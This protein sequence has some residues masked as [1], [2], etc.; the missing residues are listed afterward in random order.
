MD[1][2]ETAI[3][4]DSSLITDHCS[5]GTQ[6]SRAL[7][8]G[9]GLIKLLTSDKKLILLS[10]HSSCP[11]CNRSFEE[12]DPRLFS[13]NSPHG[14]CTE[15]R[16]HGR[17]PKRRHHLDTSRF[18]SVLA[19]ELDADRSIERMDDTE[20]IACPAC[21]GSRLNP[22]A[23]AVRL[24]GVW[25]SRPQ[26]SL[27]ISDLSALSID[28]SQNHFNKLT[29]EESRQNLIARDI[30]PEIRQR[31]SFLQEVG[32]GYLQLDRSGNTLSGGESQRIR[33]A[34][35]LGSNLR[36]VLYVL[37]EPTIGLH[38]RDNAALLKT[39][40]KLRD[41]GNSLIIVE[42]DED[43]IAAADHLIDLGPAAGRLGGEIVY[44]GKPP[45]RSSQF[46]VSNLKSQDLTS[47]PP[48]SA[49]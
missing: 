27:S 44:Q 3:S 37:D 28:S 43:T 29:F 5:L 4:K 30:L 45:C 39:L 15:C 14:W 13:F 22:T 11:S 7:E 17:V 18:D 41:H 32:L 38:P 42:H 35:Q 21:Q 20:L 24:Q 31:L 47:I 8:I 46:Q 26:S 19:A 1:K 10:T 36:G 9:K 23:S 25:A 33:L 34:A 2:R 16:G 6:V 48:P 12:L 40:I 49:R